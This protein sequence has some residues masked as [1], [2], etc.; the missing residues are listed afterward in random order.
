MGGAYI[1]P[2]LVKRSNDW[3]ESCINRLF[4]KYD[5]PARVRAVCPE[6]PTRT[7]WEV[8]RLN[9]A[10]EEEVAKK[11]YAVQDRIGQRPAIMAD[12]DEALFMAMSQ[13]FDWMRQSGSVDD[14][15]YPHMMKNAGIWLTIFRLKGGAA[16]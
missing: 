6:T 7:I 2:D 12:K 1:P 16:N 14:P 5:I 10:T 3:T 4:E 8:K 11:I 15:S 13:M 9:N